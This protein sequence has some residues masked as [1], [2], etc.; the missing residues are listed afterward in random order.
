MSFQ[1]D[2]NDFELR[3]ILHFIGDRMK[4]GRLLLMSGG[5]QAAVE[6][7]KGKITRIELHKKPPLVV[8]LEEAGFVPGGSAAKMAAAD[9]DDIAQRQM[10]LSKKLLD[11]DDFNRFL[12]REIA[13]DLAELMFWA[14]AD[15]EFSI[16][17]EPPPALVELK[18]DDAVREAISMSVELRN[19]KKRFPDGTEIR[20]GASPIGKMVTID[21]E[22]WE[23]IA[24][25]TKSIKIEELAKSSGRDSFSFYELLARV[26]DRGLLT[27]DERE[28]KEER[29]EREEKPEDKPEKKLEV[30]AK[31]EAKVEAKPEPQADVKPETPDKKPETPIN[32][33]YVAVA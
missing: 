29:E 12:V 26:A 3:E 1:G 6:F 23:M 13:K 17:D 8:R 22:E 21:P 20:L 15:F 10:I 24:R 7:G 18:V 14:E 16:M 31:A 5:K 28:E 30:A 11:K 25:F 4:D 27:V 19:L 9:T 32:G 33:K 2:L